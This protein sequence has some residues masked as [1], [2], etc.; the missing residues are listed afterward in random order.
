MSGPGSTVQDGVEVGEQ[1]S[2]PGFA[3][4]FAAGDMARV[5][6]GEGSLRLEHRQ[7]A[8]D[9]GALVGETILRAADRH[10]PHRV[11]GATYLRARRRR[12]P[13][14]PVLSCAP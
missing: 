5:R 3:S 7:A 9:H 11:A 6:G 12:P 2:V 14:P 4:V 10:P 1:L 8:A 13:T